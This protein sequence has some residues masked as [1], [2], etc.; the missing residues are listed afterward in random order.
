MD[1]NA[2]RQ[3]DPNYLTW[4]LEGLV[5]DDPRNVVRVDPETADLAGTAMDRMLRI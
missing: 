5:E 3:I 2:M 4:I 1:C